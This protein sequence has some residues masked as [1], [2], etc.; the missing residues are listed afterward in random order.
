MWPAQERR[1]EGAPRVKVKSNIT[2]NRDTE[3]KMNEKYRE[4]KK[5]EKKKKKE[6]KNGYKKSEE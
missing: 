6:K 4:E 5:R 2:S 1:G 3:C